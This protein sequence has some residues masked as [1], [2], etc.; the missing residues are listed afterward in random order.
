MPAGL[1]PCSALSAAVLLLCGCAATT[2]SGS[3]T[4]TLAESGVQAPAPPAA[5]YKLSQDEQGLDCKKLSG[6]MQVRILQIRDYETRAKTTALSRTLQTATTTVIGGSQVGTDPDG[7]Y[8]KDRAMLE[9]YNKQL[10]AKGCHTFDLEAE[11]KQI[12]P[13]AVPMAAAKPT[14]TA[15]RAKGETEAAASTPRAAS[16]APSPAP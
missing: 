14:G 10:A 1:R 3:A 8:A 16:S 11:L 6:R 13:G 9:A 5:E 12:S 4:N 2:G 15:A 7:R